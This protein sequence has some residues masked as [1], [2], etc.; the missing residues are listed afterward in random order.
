MTEYYSWPINEKA[1]KKSGDKLS[2]KFNFRMPAIYKSKKKTSK[3]RSAED[4]MYIRNGYRMD[5][6][7]GI[8]V[9][10]KGI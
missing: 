6:S 1:P 5:V 2:E 4:E 10:K 7:G 8:L 9:W 3:S